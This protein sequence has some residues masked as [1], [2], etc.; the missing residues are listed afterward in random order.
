MSHGIDLTS[1][2]SEAVLLLAGL[3]PFAVTSGSDVGKWHVI[4]GE[5]LEVRPYA[6][7]KPWPLPDGNLPVE[8]SG[9]GVNLHLGLGQ[10]VNSVFS[11]FLLR[12]FIRCM[13]G[14]KGGAG[15]GGE[16]PAET[17]KLTYGSRINDDESDLPVGPAHHKKFHIRQ[18]MKF[19]ESNNRKV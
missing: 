11:I 5:D 6:V 16:I 8:G 17:G 3:K 13:Q 12:I 2:I 1:E 7:S 19:A 4:A 15:K 18:E 14:F 9:L 10:S